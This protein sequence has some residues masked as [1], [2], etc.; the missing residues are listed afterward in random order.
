M[1]CTIR[2]TFFMNSPSGF[3]ELAEI[4]LVKSYRKTEFESLSTLNDL[5]NLS[6][7]VQEL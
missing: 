1:V 7:K 4:Q 6:M 3:R 5:L 2:L